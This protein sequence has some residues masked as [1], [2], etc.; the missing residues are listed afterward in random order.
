MFSSHMK[1]EYEY[2]VLLKSE[3]FPG[4]DLCSYWET[5]WRVRRPPPELITVISCN[6]AERSF[7]QDKLYK[8]NTKPSKQTNA[9]KQTT[10]RLTAYYTEDNFSML[11]QPNV[12]N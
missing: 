2:L 3:S 1:H 8:K 9:K 4:R 7:C 12:P 11:N 10:V 6:Q 5:L